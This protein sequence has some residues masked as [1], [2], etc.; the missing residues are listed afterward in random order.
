MERGRARRVEWEG[1]V[2]KA[3]LIRTESQYKR[4]CS[5]TENG[6]CSVLSRIDNM[7]I[8]HWKWVTAVALE[9]RARGKTNEWY[10][11]F[12][13]GPL[14]HKS[15]SLPRINTCQLFAI[16]ANL[17]SLYKPTCYQWPQSANVKSLLGGFAAAG[18]CQV[19]MPCEICTALQQSKGQ[20]V[21]KC[22]CPDVYELTSNYPTGAA[23]QCLSW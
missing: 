20:G 19:K 18:K 8:A 11:F 10:K 21:V 9:L 13:N 22:P 7:T 4:R 14:F 23:V 12:Q 15:P 5:N 17:A 1:T 2:T 3:L 16:S 6:N